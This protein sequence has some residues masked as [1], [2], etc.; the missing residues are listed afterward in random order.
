MDTSPIQSVD[1]S[2]ILRVQD[3][4]K[5]FQSIPKYI[6]DVSELKKEGL[7][8]SKLKDLIYRFSKKIKRRSKLRELLGIFVYKLPKSL[9]NF[10]LSGISGAA[11]IPSSLKHPS[12]YSVDLGFGLSTSKSPRVSI[13]IPVHNHW[14]TT[15]QCLKSLQKNTDATPY[16]VILVDDASTDLTWEAAQ[17]IRGIRIIKITENVGYLRATNLGAAYAEAEYIVLLNNDTEPISGWLDSL[18]LELDKDNSVAICGSTLIYPTGIL[19]ESGGQIF[20]G[21]NAWNLGRGKDPR[22]GMYQIRRE[23]DYVSAASIIVRKSFWR[24]VGGYDEQ[25]APAYCED[26]D[27]CLTAWQLGYKVIVT[28]ES[29]VIHH[30]GVSHGTSTSSGLKAFQVKNVKKFN[31]KWSKTLPN[32]W[33]DFGVPRIERIRHSKGI[34]FVADRQLPSIS[35]DAGSIRTVQIITHLIN[36]NYHVVLTALDTSTTEADI[37]YLQKIGIEVH[38]NWEDALEAL[39]VRGIRVSHAWLFRSEVV[40][41]FADRIKQLL[42]NTKIIADLMDLD[43]EWSN[44]VTKISSKQISIANGA[45]RVIL[46]S[47]TEA[48]LLESVIQHR[49]VDVLW[50]EYPVK[51][52]EYSFGGSHGLI[53]VGGFRHKPNIEG[54]LWFANSVLPHLK[55]LNFTAPIRVVGSGLSLTHID[56]LS[57]AGI[58]VLGKQDNLQE[59]YGISRVAIVPLLSGR[60][61]KGKIGEAMSYGVPVVTTSIGS[62]GFGFDTESFILIS[63][64]PVQFAHNIILAHE[65]Q[66]EWE[67][68]SAFGKR[69]CSERLNTNRMLESIRSIIEDP[70]HD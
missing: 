45:E 7:L 28:P 54:I 56:L 60:G 22:N 35:R 31:V 26:S 23:V 55:K 33:I 34:I 42:V 37:G 68:M 41:F 69:Y 12:A 61:L 44:S 36:L 14:F 53:F 52:S 43:Y 25:F 39:R 21:G 27:L 8:A 24:E 64:N 16:E 40:D 19:Q 1:L 67:S 65:N 3:L 30:E 18:V 70:S 57:K 29:W 38:L 10:V 49:K 13:V 2:E 32:H 20:S 5:R 63:D 6:N 9:R 58:E 48:K 59:I 4:N 62:E 15:L 11:S 66:S 50:A 46:V 47:P 51:E 17:N